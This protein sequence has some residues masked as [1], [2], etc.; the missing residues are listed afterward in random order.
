MI[1]ALPGMGADHRVFPSPWNTIPGIVL[2]DWPRYRGEK[3]LAEVAKSVCNEF[4][5]RDGDSLVGVS[6][7]GMV[8]C[9]ITKLVQMRSLFLVASATNKTEMNDVLATLHPLAEV[10]PIAA[11]QFLAGK[12]R[13]ELAVMFQQSDPEFVRAMCRAV[14][15]WDG[16]GTDS[17]ACF[18]IHGRH[19]LVIPPPRKTDL[20][21]DGGHLISMTHAQ[22]CVEF[23]AA[24]CKRG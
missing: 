20:L 12:T 11:I 18:R 17:V 19:D 24:A 21:L 16:F 14:F 4:G 13:H 22:Q 5:I 15:A 9:E 2:H 10:A 8:A 1:H 3:T 23:V 7:G 6:L